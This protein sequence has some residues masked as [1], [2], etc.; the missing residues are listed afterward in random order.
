MGIIASLDIDAQKGFTPLCP[1][2]LPVPGGDEIAAALNAQATLAALRIGSKDAHPVNA[3]WVVKSPSE[4]LLPLSLPNADLTWPAHCVPGTHGFE[5][6]DGLPAPIDYDFFVWKGVEPDL[7]PYGACYHDLAE[8]RSTGLLEFLQ[9]RGVDTVIVGGLA[10]DYCVKT[11]ALQLRRAGLRVILHLAACRGIAADT[12][13][14]ALVAMA[15]AGIE[16]AADLHEV[17]RLLGC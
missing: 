9:V 11:S 3:S 4:M 7:H 13:S 15:E 1:Q 8:R 10:T 12:V 6:L 16:L 5:L 17:R 2:E 14:T